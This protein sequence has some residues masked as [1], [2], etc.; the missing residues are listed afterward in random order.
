MSIA[1]VGGGLIGCS[2][3]LELARAGRRV[4][5]YE[6][7]EIGRQASWAAGGVLTPVHLADYPAPLAEL[8]L[9]SQRMYAAWAAALEAPEIEYRVCGMLVLIHDDDDERDAAKLEGERLSAAEARRLEPWLAPDLRGALDVPH[10]AQVRNCRLTRAVARA[11]AR[12][13]AEIREHAEAQPAD[14]TVVATGAWAEHVRPARGQ[15]IL[16]AGGGEIRRVLLW[17]DRYIIPRLDGRLLMGSTVE[18]VGFDASTTEAGLEAI[19]RDIARIAPRAVDLPVE[20]VWA[21]L[22]PR[23]VDRL[24]II[25]VEGSTIWATGH[26]RNGILLAPITARLVREIVEGV[27][28]SVKLDP[29]AP[30]RFGPSR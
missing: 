30:S 10:V 1:V 25:G 8:C 23:T 9:A 21:G 20:R 22:R 17:K 3:A 16:A 27:E 13:G 7:A 24:P 12:A 26:F 2:V 6:R 14:R 11:A 18:D 15:M 28:P 29:F 19:R 4:T 5:L